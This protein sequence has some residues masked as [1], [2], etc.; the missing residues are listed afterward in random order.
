MKA[1]AKHQD[2]IVVEHMAIVLMAHINI[3]VFPLNFTGLAV[4]D[5]QQIQQ[6]VAHHNV[7]IC[8]R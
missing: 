3:V 2:I 1:V 6:A 8:K 7:A 4:N 5:D